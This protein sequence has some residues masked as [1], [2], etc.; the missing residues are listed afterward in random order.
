[1]LAPP[2]SPQGLQ[3]SYSGRVIELT[4][5]QEEAAVMWVSATMNPPE[6]AA[7][8]VF[9][10]NFMNDWQQVLA[11]TEAGRQVQH[12]EQCDFSMIRAALEKVPRPPRRSSQAREAAEAP[13]AFAQLDAL[14]GVE[15]SVY[16]F[17]MMPPMIFRGRGP[18][19]LR[20][21]ISTRVLPEQVTLNLDAKSPLPAIPDLGNGVKHTWGAVI[22]N[23]SVPWLARWSD[24]GTGV[25]NYSFTN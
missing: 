8:S 11:A 22:S 18:H 13:F 6:L 20:G 19:P 1:M 7:D 23:D 14:D 12:L 3:I 16:N 25:T 5:L 15:R 21:R 4:P 17:L 10:S 9:T 24:P 2:Y